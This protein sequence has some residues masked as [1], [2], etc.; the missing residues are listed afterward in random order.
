MIGKAETAVEQKYV[1]FFLSGREYAIHIKRIVEI[2]Y[3]RKSTPMPDAPS[4]VEGVVDL[5]GKVI[6]VIDLK[7]ILLVKNLEE[8]EPSH[9]LI[10]Q[11]QKKM[12]GIVVDKVHEVL[13][14]SENRIQSPQTVLKGKVS[15]HLRG[16][17]KV[18]NRMIFIL[19]MDNMLTPEAAGL[20]G[21]KK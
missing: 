8:V 10:I 17:S 7:K 9:I 18:G 14:I 3:F 15:K 12:L 19:S 2:I 1:G 21:G 11:F 6:P 13:Q 5:R 16:V 4:F 20:L